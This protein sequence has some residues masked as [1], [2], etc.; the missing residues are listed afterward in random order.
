MGHFV[1]TIHNGIEYGLKP[2][3]VYRVKQRPDF[4]L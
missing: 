2:L 3:P 1:K 4:V